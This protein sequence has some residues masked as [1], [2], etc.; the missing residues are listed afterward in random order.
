MA[1]ALTPVIASTPQE[2][3]VAI[4][5]AAPLLL[6]YGTFSLIRAFIVKRTTELA[7]TTKRVV[8]KAG[9]IRRDTVDLNHTRVESYS[10]SQSVLGRLLDYGTVIVRGTGGATTP[11]RGVSAPLEFRR[12]AAALTDAQP[13]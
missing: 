7:L 12:Q 13:A 6:L 1:I 2:S 11:I 4:A 8:A 5:I 3:V 9:F 10:V